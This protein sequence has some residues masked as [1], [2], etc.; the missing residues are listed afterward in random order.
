MHL[1]AAKKMLST[2]EIDVTQQ[3]NFH[4]KQTAVMLCGPAAGKVI[5]GLAT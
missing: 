1:L 5:V 3:Y 2:T 4:L